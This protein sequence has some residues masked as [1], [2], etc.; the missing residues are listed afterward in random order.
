MEQCPIRWTGNNA[1]NKRDVLGT[2]VLAILCGRYRCADI[3]ALRGDTVNA[4]LLGM[5]KVVSEDSVRRMLIKLDETKGV[6][7]LQHDLLAV[8]ESLLGEP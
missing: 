3:S 6:A 4:A 1:P 2:A 8:S 7:W 5:E